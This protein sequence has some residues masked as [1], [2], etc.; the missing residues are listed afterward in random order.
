M[1]RGLG[2]WLNARGATTEELDAIRIA[3][4]EACSNSIEHGCRFGPGS[5][6]VEADTGA[7]GVVLEVRDSGDWIDRHDGPLPF[8]GHG[9]PLM[10]ALVD[11]VDIQHSQAGTT[12]RLRR[13]LACQATEG[14]SST[15]LN[16]S[17]TR[18]SASP[19]EGP[20]ST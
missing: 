11:A 13:Q 8:R 15:R 19:S 17:G 4:H 2:R 5:V 18:A 16:G 7:E 6:T 20:S 14:C 9:L 1:R 10:E 3:C 12:V